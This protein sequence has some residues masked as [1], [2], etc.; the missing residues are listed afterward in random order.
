MVLQDRIAEVEQQKQLMAESERNKRIDARNKLVDK[1][2][3]LDRKIQQLEPE[4]NELQLLTKNG[5]LNTLG[6][7]W[8]LLVKSGTLKGMK[9]NSARLEQEI[10]SIKV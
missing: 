7:R 10:R 4:V 9:E 8:N 2:M 5:Q 6:K 1:K 3:K